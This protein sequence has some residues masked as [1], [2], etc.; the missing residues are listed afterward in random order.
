MKYRNCY[1]TTDFREDDQRYHGTITGLFEGEISA[2][3][4]D[5]FIE[6]FHQKVDDYIERKT[7]EQKRRRWVIWGIVAAIIVIAVVTCPKKDKHVSV[8][9]DRFNAAYALQNTGLDGLEILGGMLVGSIATSLLDS[10]LTVDD[11]VLFSI[12][13]FTFDGE[14]SLISIGAFGHIITKSVKQMQEAM[15]LE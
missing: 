2:S 6:K 8:L 5:D 15:K 10:Y 7:A 12:G 3:N 9:T 11:Y 14:R 13:R 4:M 1:C